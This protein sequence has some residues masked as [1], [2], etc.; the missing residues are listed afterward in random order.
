MNFEQDYIMRQVQQFA[1]ALEK[2][3]FKKKEG[4]RQEAQ[5]I[6]EQSLNKLPDVNDRNIQEL[7]LD[8]T[9]SVL[10][11]EGTF[12]SELALIIADLFFEKGKLVDKN[13]SQKCYMQALLLYQKAMKDHNV[14][15]PLQATQKISQIKNELDPSDLEKVKQLLK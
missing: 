3:L 1:D 13:E 4:K 5:D 10:E 14:A 7:S 15:F 2:V 6:I 8:N 9:I 11:N 12:N